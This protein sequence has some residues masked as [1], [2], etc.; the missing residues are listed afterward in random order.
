LERLVVTE[1]DV[2]REEIDVDG[3]TERRN[4]QVEPSVSW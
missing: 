2:G 3:Q 1:E 4:V